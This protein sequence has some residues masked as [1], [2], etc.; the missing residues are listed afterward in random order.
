[1]RPDPVLNGV[2]SKMIARENQE[3]A[4]IRQRSPVVETYIQK[5]RNIENDGT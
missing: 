3:M 2:I 5:V 4:L 1:M